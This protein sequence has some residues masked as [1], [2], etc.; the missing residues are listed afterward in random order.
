MHVYSSLAVVLT[1]A[2]L[3]SSSILAKEKPASLQ[4]GI[5]ARVPESECTIKTQ[6]GD[7]LSMHYTGKLWEGAKF[8]SS[9]DRGDPF[10]F[11]IGTGQV[12]KGWDQGLLDMC[13]GEKRKLQIPPE[14]GYGARGAGGSIP[15]DSTLVFDVE[16]LGID[17]PRANALK[18]SKLHKDEL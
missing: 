1:T 2:L 4:V 14:L 18:A 7:R 6:N 13:I 8:D 11:T 16:L 3:F 17:A 15:P 12:I 5:K 9:L 10:E